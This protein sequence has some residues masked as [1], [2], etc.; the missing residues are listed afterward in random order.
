MIGQRYGITAV[1]RKRL[2]A[3]IGKVGMKELMNLNLNL[4]L[5]RS[6]ESGRWHFDWPVQRQKVR[7]SEPGVVR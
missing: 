6:A 1:A 3:K 5:M 7:S 2:K 4:N